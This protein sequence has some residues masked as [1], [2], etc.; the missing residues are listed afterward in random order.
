M[1]NRDREREK[2]EF[3]RNQD[4]WGPIIAAGGILL[5]IITVIYIIAGLF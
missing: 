4:I 5:T 2:D 3:L 1:S